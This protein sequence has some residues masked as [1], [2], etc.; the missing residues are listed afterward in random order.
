ML[1]SIATNGQT[2]ID[3]KFKTYTVNEGL[4]HNKVNKTVMDAQGFLWIATEGG[5]SRFDGVTFTNFKNELP[6]SDIKDI[7]ISKDG[8][9]WLCG[10]KGLFTFNVFTQQIQ[11][12]ANSL[13]NDLVLK[14]EIDAKNE[15]T[16]F[17]NQSQSK[18]CK[19]NWKNNWIDT[20]GFKKLNEFG[21]IFLFN[22]I[23][24]LAE[25]R[26]GIIAFTIANSSFKTYFNDIWP[27]K[28]NVIN[29]EL[30]VCCWQDDLFKFNVKEDSF[31][32]YPLKVLD[33]SA[34]NRY[35][36]ADMKPITLTNKNYLLLG[37]NSCAGLG[38]YD[39]SEKRMIQEI[40]K[41]FYSKN[42]IQSNFTDHI[43]RDKFNNYWV[44]TWNGLAF[45]NLEDQQFITKEFA[46]LDTRNY[47]NLSGIA[48]DRKNKDILWIGA[49]GSG[50]AKYNVKTKRIERDFFNQIVNGE[51]I[52]YKERWTEFLQ[53]DNHNTIWS[54]GYN[55]LVKIEND[56]TYKYDFD[57]R[58]GLS[59]VR[60]LLMQDEE[61]FWATTLNK[62]LIKFNPK[63]GK[64]KSYN[65]TNSAIGSNAIQ[66][67]IP[68]SKNKLWVCTVDD[69][70]LFDIK[71]EQFTPQN[72][73]FN[74]EKIIKI[75]NFELDRFNTIYISNNKGT[76]YKT[77]NSSVF[78]E[79][80][81]VKSIVPIYQ[82]SIKIDQNN[83]LWIY[84]VD[85]LFCYNPNTKAIIRYDQKDGLYN[86]TSDPTR[87]FEFEDEL[88]LGY[89]M[90]YTKFNP[91]LLSISKTRPKPIITAIKLNKKI[92]KSYGNSKEN[93]LAI[94]Y[95]DNVID[96]VY[97]AI[98]YSF[99]EK[100]KF[101]YQLEGFDK[102]WIS[103]GHKR[104]VRYTNLNGGNYIF[105]LKAIAHNGLASNEIEYFYIKIIPPF[106]QTWWFKLLVILL[107]L[108][109][110]YF[111]YRLRIGIIKRE[112]KTKTAYNKQ[113]AEL[114]SKALRSQ[115]NPHFVFN[116]LNSI[117]N[118]IVKND[119]ESSSKYL[120]KF[121]K[122]TRLI[123]DHSQQKLITLKQELSALKTYVELEQFRFSN[124]F[125]FT[126]KVEEKIDEQAIEIPPLIIQ[127]FVENAIWHGIM[128]RDE[129]N[130]S[131]IG[132]IEITIT[133]EKEY[134]QIAISDNGIGRVKSAELKK[135][136]TTDHQSSG[137]KLTQERLDIMNKNNQ[138]EI[139]SKIIDL[140]DDNNQA[141]GTKVV[142]NIPLN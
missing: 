5:L 99:A 43:L 24:Y 90:A 111:I 141:I 8:R 15:C 102:N 107:F 18:L 120:S 63:T 44:S 123:F 105:K 56:Q 34:A 94:S 68:A 131:V 119:S 4:V 46:H 133:Q 52:H 126:I 36:V 137:M 71:T 39:L 91:T 84:A 65:I 11:V 116:S 136:S 10:A 95:R 67:V 142:I 74:G 64:F 85:G 129:E 127:P 29:N 50:I 75:E 106:W 121:A 48:R 100:T 62:G 22:N 57:D 135:M 37:F 118:Y 81:Y 124:K 139:T 140:Y 125:N 28:F 89:R 12:F 96:I 2:D 14:I 83:H 130:A 20:F 59:F 134:L 25:S 49:N 54:G 23:L 128:H 77:E 92:G 1:V 55:G 66:K 27:M 31:Y 60:N 93:P 42:S 73:Q 38:L 41:D 13:A 16:W 104:Q 76:Y 7:E 32:R 51:D 114:E 80:K 117:Q 103:A 87:I 35:I 30:W 86:I 98:N 138:L 19:L 72:I 6:F 78:L 108:G 112:E 26:K 61:T 79:I 101:Y 58:T 40:K 45:L 110:V 70:V 17:V 3:F 21:D 132:E 109:L 88:Y 82:N 113:I 53:I 122:L 97:T 69:L 33:T 9:L 115:M 47:N